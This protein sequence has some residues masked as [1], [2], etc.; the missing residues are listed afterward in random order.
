ML[1]EVAEQFEIGLILTVVCT[2]TWSLPK[3]LVLPQPVITPLAFR[4]A[5]LFPCVGKQIGFISFVY[6]TGA[7]S[8]ISAISCSQRVGSPW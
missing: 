2:K 4:T 5:L 6:V 7:D 8:F 1:S 3:P